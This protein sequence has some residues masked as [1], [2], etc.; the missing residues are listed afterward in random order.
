[1][2]YYGA[3]EDCLDSAESCFAEELHEAELEMHCRDEELADGTYV[4]EE[5]EEPTEP[6]KEQIAAMFADA[7]QS[8]ADTWLSDAIH[9]RNDAR[10]RLAR[11]PDWEEERERLAWAE[12]AIK[13]FAENPKYPKA[14]MAAVAEL[15]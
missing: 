11:H 3:E 4:H 9:E 10:L 8:D 14:Q 12:S 13:R 6:T 7:E 5:S 2:N 1:M 15:L